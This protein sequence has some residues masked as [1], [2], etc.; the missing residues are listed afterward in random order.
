M[1]K[2]SCILVTGGH[3]TP[4]LACIDE[5]ID[6][7]YKNI[8]YIGQKKSILFDKNT[9]SEHKVFS[10]K[11]GVKFVG[12]H[13]GKLSKDLSLDSIIWILR[14]PFGFIETFFVFLKYNPSVVLTFGSHVGLPPTVIAKVFRKRIVAHEQTVVIGRSNELIYKFADKICISWE[15]SIQKLVQNNIKQDKIVYTGNPVR[16]EIRQTAY[17]S[18]E[19][20]QL[21]G[22]VKGKSNTVLT[23][24]N[25]EQASFIYNINRNK[26]TIFITGG[27]Q[28]SN[29]INEVIFKNLE[30]LLNKYN[31]I[32]QTGANSV[33]NNYEKAIKLKKKNI[34]NNSEF[35][36]YFPY[37]YLTSKDMALAIKVSNLL[38]S[39][40]GAN[41]LTELILLRKK[42]ILV[43]IP[44]SSNNEQDLNAKMLEDMGLGKVIEQKNYVKLTDLT[45]VVEHFLED[46]HVE[47]PNNEEK[48]NIHFN[49][50]K[51][52]IEELKRI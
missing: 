35:A 33:Y 17:E 24:T 16:K 14:I 5:L 46:V 51:K 11:S 45:K 49:A 23:K 38:I 47:T 37:D 7:G 44:N 20:K 13:P 21:H 19:D 48:F 32:H 39:R 31:V 36:N 10:N 3:L 9:S 27:N 28:G 8:L 41:T 1:K 34:K 43:P 42:A 52:I 12:Y 2:N 4:A 40:A 6:Q 50:H 30:K 18:K 29:V 26:K 25:Q 22:V 15:S